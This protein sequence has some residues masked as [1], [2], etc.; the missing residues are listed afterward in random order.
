MPEGR[1]RG[2]GGDDSEVHG[3][4]EVGPLL[5]LGGQRGPILTMSPPHR[6]TWPGCD[7][8]NAPFSKNAPKSAGCQP[9][10]YA[11][12]LHAKFVSYPVRRVCKREKQKEASE[13]KT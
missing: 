9:V 7:A 4:G 10:L 1:R 13:E 12:P 5:G 8:R 2:G 3:G 11:H 6:A